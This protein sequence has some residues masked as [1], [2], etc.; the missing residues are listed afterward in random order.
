VKAEREKLVVAKRPFKE[1]LEYIEQVAPCCFK[2][3]QGFVYGMR[4][5][6]LIYVNQSLW[7]QVLEELHDFSESGH[8][9]F[10]PAV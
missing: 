3:K 7:K 2:I 10:I 5:E 1:E 6:G 9:G 4:T 8:G